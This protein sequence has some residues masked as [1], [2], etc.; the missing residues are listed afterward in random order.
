MLAANKKTSGTWYPYPPHIMYWS[1]ARS[2][3]AAFS[4]HSALLKMAIV[5][6]APSAMVN[7]DDVTNNSP[8][9]P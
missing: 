2:Y 5:S 6:T 7:F 9:R 1:T 8:A 4:K 3:M